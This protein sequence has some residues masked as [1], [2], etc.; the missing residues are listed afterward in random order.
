MEIIEKHKTVERWEVR[1]ASAVVLFAGNNLRSARVFADPTPPAPCAAP[2]Y[3]QFDF[4]VG[5]WDVFEVGGRS[6]SR[7]PVL[8][9]FSMA[10]SCGRTTKQAMDTKARVS[11]FTRPPS[12]FTPGGPL[13]DHYAHRQI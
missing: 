7:T 9:S 2:V 6:K 5:D 4:W 11:Q 10:A 8:T 1:I 13:F 12:D 3:R